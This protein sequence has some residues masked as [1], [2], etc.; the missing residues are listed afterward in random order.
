[1]ASVIRTIDLGVDADAVW[2]AVRDVGAAHRRLVP[3]VLDDVTLEPGGRVVRFAIGFVVRERIVTI[4]DA[5]RRFAYAAHGGRTTF[6]HASMQ[7]EA[8]GPDRA[9]L[10]WITD[11]LPDDAAP[12]VAALVDLGAAAMRRAFGDGD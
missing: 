6:H 1:M 10:T 5:R 12:Q 3:G 9:R 4:D 7:V 11:V 2:D 8:V